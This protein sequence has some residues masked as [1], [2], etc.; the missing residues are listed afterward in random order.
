M[1][2]R[3]TSSSTGRYSP[4]P[5]SATGPGDVRMIILRLGIRK[6]DVR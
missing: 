4:E 3:S 2:L 5:T 6:L 1:R